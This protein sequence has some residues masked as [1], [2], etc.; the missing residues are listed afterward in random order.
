MPA[1]PPRQLTHVK[2]SEPVGR[3]LT[4]RTEA[5]FI[6]SFKYK[7]E[8]DYGFKELQ[9]RHLK[10]FQNFLDMVSGMTF[11]QVDKKFRRPSDKTDVYNEKDVIHYQ[12][13]DSFRIHGVIEEGRFKVIRLDP[14]HKFHR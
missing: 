4:K 9:S 5:P 7:L 13:K 6:I 3:S 12:V 8:S 11:Q 10:Q 1:R 14:S 2:A